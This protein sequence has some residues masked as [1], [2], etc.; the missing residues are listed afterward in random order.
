VVFNLIHGSP[1]H[2]DVVGEALLKIIQIPSELRPLS[3][4]LI[5]IERLPLEKVAFPLPL[6]CRNFGLRYLKAYDQNWTRGA[7]EDFFGIAA[8]QQLFPTDVS[9]RR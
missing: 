6:L 3:G 4:L 5:C 7:F 1:L 9:M 2:R 8:E